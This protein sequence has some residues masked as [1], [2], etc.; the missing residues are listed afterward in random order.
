MKNEFL[1]VAAL[2]GIA[3][4]CVIGLFGFVPGLISAPSSF[5]NLMGLVIAVAIIALAVV[6]SMKLY[7]K[8]I[9]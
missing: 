2:I 9:K 5:Q 8:Y 1:D 4:V 6:V 7:R 3:L